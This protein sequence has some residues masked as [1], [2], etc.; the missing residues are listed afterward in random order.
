MIDVNDRTVFR[1]LVR[2]MIIMDME[3]DLRSN[4]Q[5]RQNKPKIRTVH[6]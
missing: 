4:L 3:D 5:K 1:A 2:T 6:G